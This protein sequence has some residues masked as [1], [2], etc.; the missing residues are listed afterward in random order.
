MIIGFPCNQVSPPLSRG[1]KLRQRRLIEMEDEWR[2]KEAGRGNS[3]WSYVRESRL[4]SAQFKAQEPGTDDEV[5][6]FCQMN[7]GVTFPIAKKVSSAP[8]SLPPFS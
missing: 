6:Q 7:Y 3:G 8:A 4:I 5:L 2:S 1:G